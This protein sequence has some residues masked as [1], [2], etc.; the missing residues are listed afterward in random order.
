MYR[1]ELWFRGEV[2]VEM[3]LLGQ[4]ISC[5]YGNLKFHYRFHRSRQWIYIEPDEFNPHPRILFL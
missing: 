4:E 2:L 5:I 1:I 3:A